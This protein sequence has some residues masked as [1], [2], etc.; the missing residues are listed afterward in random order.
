L[1]NE[2]TAVTMLASL[3]IIALV[4]ATYAARLK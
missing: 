2:L 3:G 1:M 4:L